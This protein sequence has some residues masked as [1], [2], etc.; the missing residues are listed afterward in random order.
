MVSGPQWQLMGEI[1]IIFILVVGI[2]VG[3]LVGMAAL[4]AL[5]GWIL[6]SEIDAEYVDTEFLELTK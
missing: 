5:L 3:F 6:K 4:A 1:I 2:P